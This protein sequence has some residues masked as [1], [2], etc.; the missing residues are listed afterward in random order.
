MNSIISLVKFFF[1][2]F[3]ISSYLLVSSLFYPLIKFFPI[4]GKLVLNKMI[5]LVSKLLLIVLN[6]QVDSN[7]KKFPKD[8][9][10]IVGN[11]LSYIDI[12]VLS[13]YLPT[14]FVTS[15]EMKRTPVL[16]QICTLAGC[17]FV[18]RRSRSNIKNEISEIS[19]ALKNGINVTVFPEATSTNGE[20]V[21]PFK[22]SLF[23]AA[24]E[25]KKEVLPVTINYTAVNGER[26]SRANR[27][28]V[29]WYGD[30]E[31]L[32]HLFDLCKQKVIH[33]DLNWELN[34][35]CTQANGLNDVLAQ[36][37]EKV[38][39]NYNPIMA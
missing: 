3:I 37:F 39:S 25:A 2:L 28:F 31:F 7:Y 35:I 22:R 5:S 11:H 10:F 15:M 9:F 13:S 38:S 6:I 14:S 30:M 26:L 1:V 36:S 19:E 23:Q 12:L 18:E 16:G 21:L 4:K 24:I 34:T 20:Q 29:C 33:V 27:D 32:P 17:L 8:N